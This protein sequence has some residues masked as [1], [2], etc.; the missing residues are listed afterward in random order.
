[1]PQM[2][3]LINQI[4]IVVKRVKKMTRMKYLR[5]DDEKQ[6]KTYLVHKTCK[7]E[8]EPIP[9]Y[10]FHCLVCDRKVGVFE[11]S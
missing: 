6:R 11:I 4:S 9:E 8:I 10:G 2:Q 3:K 5:D 7:G 1:M